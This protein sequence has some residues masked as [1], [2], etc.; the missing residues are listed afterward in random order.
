MDERGILEFMLASLHCP[1]PISTM[2]LRGPG[3]SIYKRGRRP[4]LRMD[5]WMG[6]DG[7]GIK[8]VLQFSSY[9]VRT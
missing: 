9:F 3:L 1:D 4:S 2:S 5:G 8:S 6:W 7:W